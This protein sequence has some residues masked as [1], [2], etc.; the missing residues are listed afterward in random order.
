MESSQSENLL[1]IPGNNIFQSSFALKANVPD[2]FPGPILMIPPSDPQRLQK[3][4]ITGLD[5]SYNSSLY[6]PRNL[7]IP[8]GD[9]YKLF[10]LQPFR[11]DN[12]IN[13]EKI[14]FENEN[15]EKSANV[16]EQDSTWMEEYD[17]IMTHSG[18][19]TLKQNSNS[20]KMK[21][22]AIF[23]E[24]SNNSKIKIENL[25]QNMPNISKS[26]VRKKEFT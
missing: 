8:F 17:L 4:R 22:G 20:E 26:K 5:L 23:K 11:K 13:S 14:M 18:Q 12:Q 9:L 15:H 16:L 3:P 7:H 25:E 19:K 2:P 10:E 21:K 24:K 6:I 1:K